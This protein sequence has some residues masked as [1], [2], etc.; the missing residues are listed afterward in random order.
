M[1][2]TVQDH[3][4]DTLEELGQDELKKFKSKL[5]TFHVK[6]GYNT[7]PRG[8]LEKADVLDLAQMLIGYYK[9]DYAVEVTMELLTDIN[10]RDLAERLLKETGTGSGGKGQKPVQ[11]CG[12]TQGAEEHFVDRHR[13]AL[14]QRTATVDPI[15]DILHGKVLDDE[16]YQ[17]I[18][19]ANTSQEKMRRL[20]QLMPS[21]N[22]EC[23]DR[24]YEALKAK[25]KFLVE[26]LE[27]N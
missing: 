18:R 8:R 13:A 19:A 15:L 14:I 4:V 23:K 25:H 11:P 5:N 10:K 3:L 12:A 17:T 2:K 1:V 21:W 24:L 9:E 22:R 7:I 20:Y 6:E 27:K 26:E 16:Q